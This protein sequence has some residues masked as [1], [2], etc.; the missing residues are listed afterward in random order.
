MTR[1]LIETKAINAMAEALRDLESYARVPETIATRQLLRS[2]LQIL[3]EK[4]GKVPNGSRG[5]ATAQGAI[6]VDRQAL[7]SKVSSD[8]KPRPLQI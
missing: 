2:T 7:F 8:H 3:G 6:R 4:Y 5:R 1:E